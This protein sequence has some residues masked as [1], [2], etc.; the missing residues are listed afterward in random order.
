M[1]QESSEAVSITDSLLLYMPAAL[2]DDHGVDESVHLFLV[3][4]IQLRIWR[5]AGELAD[6]VNILNDVVFGGWCPGCNDL[7]DGSS[8]IVANISA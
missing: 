6:S 3:E 1:K 7:G 2:N 4:V 5:D 8:V